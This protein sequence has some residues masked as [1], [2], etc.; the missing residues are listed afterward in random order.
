MIY[1]IITTF[2]L[3]MLIITSIKAQGNIDNVLL[4]IKKNNK[5]IK[6][7][8]QYVEAKKLQYKTG[9]TLKNPSIEYEY[10][11]GSPANAGDQT[12]FLVVQSFDFPTAYSKK[13]QVAELQIEQTNFQLTAIRQTILLEAKKT[14]LELVYYYKNRLNWKN[15]YK[16]LRN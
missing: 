16:M 8:Q 14:C 4:E 11:N 7:N 3:L 15:D 6:V 10:L 2:C 9:L 5:S 12:D 1:K 13:K